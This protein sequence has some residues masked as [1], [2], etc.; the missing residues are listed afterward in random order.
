MTARLKVRTTLFDVAE[1]PWKAQ[2]ACWGKPNV[3]HVF[4]PSESGPGDSYAAARRFCARCPVTAECLDY[5]ERTH[6]YD[7]MFGGLDDRQ[8]RSRRKAMRHNRGVAC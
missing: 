7:G 6:S 1:E 8:R 3:T 5:A 4:F 2:G